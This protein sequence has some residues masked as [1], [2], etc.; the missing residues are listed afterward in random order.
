MLPLFGANARRVLRMAA[1]QATIR[2]KSKAGR[3]TGQARKDLVM[4]AS[5][6]KAPAIKLAGH[7]D[8]AAMLR[9]AAELSRDISTAR[10]EIYWPD[11]LGSAALGYAGLTGAIMLANPWAAGA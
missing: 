2:V 4:S 1:S 11:M 3:K 8:D 7:P 6:S 5:K 9:A 10:P